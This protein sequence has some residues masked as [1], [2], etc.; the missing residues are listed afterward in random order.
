MSPDYAAASLAGTAALLSELS[1]ID[2]LCQT[3]RQSARVDNIMSAQRR[4][5]RE[6][7]YA[8]VADARL[9]H[10]LYAFALV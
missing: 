10:S 3:V 7:V 9:Q 1:S 2:L 8:G 5:V 6:V 4:L